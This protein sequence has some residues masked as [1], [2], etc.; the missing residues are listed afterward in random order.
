M[1][2][3]SIG[4][5]YG[6]ESAR[7]LLLNLETGEEVKSAMMMYPHVVMSEKLPCGKKLEPFWALQHPKDYLDVLE[8][9]IPEVIKE[10]KVNPRD[11]I[12]IGI[13]FTACTMLPTKSDGTPLCYY[14]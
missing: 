4:V 3:F 14:R 1:S 9:I 11:I 7:A 8:T 2:K 5:D 6:S 13:D 12:G 10:S